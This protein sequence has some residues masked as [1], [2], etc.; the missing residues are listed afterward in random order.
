MREQWY[1]RSGIEPTEK[2]NSNW[3][4]AAVQGEYLHE[5]M[6]DLLVTHG[7]AMGLQQLGK[8]T[9]M[10]DPD[11]KMSGRCDY[12]AWDVQKS[13][14]IGI[15]FK[16][17][18][19]WKSKKCL[20]EPSEE[21]ILQSMLYLDHFKRNIP[22]DQA[23]VKKWY[24]WYIARGEGWHL[25]GAKQ[26]SPFVQLWDFYIELDDEGTPTVFTPRGPIKYTNLNV[27]K[28]KIRFRQ[29]NDHVETNSTPDRDCELKYSEE[30]I[31]GMFKSGMIEFKGQKDTID[32]WL[33]KGATPGGLGLEMGDGQCKFCGWKSLCW[34]LPYT[35]S[36]PTF[37]LPKEKATE[38][39]E[40]TEES[41]S[42][43]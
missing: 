21:H 34:E 29:L 35:S 26:L 5:M 13:E 22:D 16:S 14:P 19:D 8:E 32:K 4:L 25:K 24:I 20:E 37:N 9:S 43:L 17:V 7:V 2:G 41:I 11:T 38:P 42:V 1:R 6:S 3:S 12:L 28:I 36:K 23:Q 30:T 18:G 39:Q 10:Y 15:E 40:A 31:V 33:N 27:N